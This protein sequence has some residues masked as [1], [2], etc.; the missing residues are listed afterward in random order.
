MREFHVWRGLDNLG[1][2]ETRARGTK[3]VRIFAELMKLWYASRVRSRAKSREGG[4]LSR[5]Y[6][7][8]GMSITGN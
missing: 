7:I 8:W 6:Q 2:C 4:A 1:F 3:S 5:L